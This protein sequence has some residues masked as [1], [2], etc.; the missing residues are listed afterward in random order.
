[1]QART[2]TENEPRAM[3]PHTAGLFSL[4]GLLVSSSPATG[5]R[6]YM[7][8]LNLP[9]LHLISYRLGHEPNKQLQSPGKA[10][11]RIVLFTALVNSV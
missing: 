2:G 9:R 5:D 10:Q 11:L 6:S 8:A 3:T 4:V 1:M 7:K